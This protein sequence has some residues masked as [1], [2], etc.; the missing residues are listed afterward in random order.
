[1]TTP[2]SKFVLNTDY[3]LLRKQKETLL[4]LVGDDHQLGKNELNGLITF[5]D[6]FQ[7]AVV[8]SQLVPEDVVF[9][10][11][12]DVNIMDVYKEKARTECAARKIDDGHVIDICASVM[13]TRD[14]VLQGGSFV[15]A[16]VNNNLTE[17]LAFADSICRENILTITVAKE[18]WY[19]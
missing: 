18:S 15:Q 8:D 7:D 14:G 3:K 9:V 1:M 5:L 17:A 12:T 13:M 6:S 10:L 11:D 19:I 4:T 16:V 2:I